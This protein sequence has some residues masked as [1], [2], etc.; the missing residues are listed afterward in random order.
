M[1]YALTYARSCG[2]GAAKALRITILADTAYY[3]CSEKAA[4]LPTS[5]KSRFVRFG[6]E[7]QNVHKTGLGS[8]AAL[9]TALVASLLYHH[10]PDM[11]ESPHGAPTVARIH[12]LAQV[13]HC[14]AQGKIGSGFD[15]A[16]AVFGSCVYRRFSPALL[17]QLKT[18]DTE[19]FPARLRSLVDDDMPNSRWDYE[20]NKPAAKMPP[21]LRLAMCDVDGG[22]E[23]RGMAKKVLAWRQAKPVD[24]SLI[25]QGL[26][27]GTDGLIAEFRRLATEAD[28]SFEKLGQTIRFI[29]SQV[30]DMSEKADV[31]IEPRSQTELLDS[32]SQLPGVIGGVVPGAGG[33]DAL[34]F[35]VEDHVAAVASLE[36]CLSQHRL[37][38]SPDR[39]NLLTE[40][41]R[42]LKTS[43][44]SQGIRIEA[45]D[46]VESWIDWE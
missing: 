5:S 38:S 3:S 19:G 12:R 24:A 1:S 34:A 4:D 42:I 21:G 17:E 25:W 13:V 29:R 14:A 44:E 45:A 8:S 27:E 11:K 30:R 46:T 35:I 22:S 16:A 18:P 36:A 28:R 32:C 43:E 23:S 33:Y 20:V 39:G 31:P 6:A 9:V 10:L 7:L 26:Q 37:Q 15:V 40:Y 41:A 2:I